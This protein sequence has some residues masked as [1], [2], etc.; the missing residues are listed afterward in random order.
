MNDEV[1]RYSIV[2]RYS[3]SGARFTFAAHDLLLQ[4]LGRFDGLYLRVPFRLMNE[5]GVQA[6]EMSRTLPLV[7]DRGSNR[8]LRYSR[9]SGRAVHRLR[10]RI[11]TAENRID[12]R[13]LLTAL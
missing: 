2:V 6:K 11:G 5:I 4:Q 7:P 8:D 9:E 13:T 3:M 1:V 10:D 12:A